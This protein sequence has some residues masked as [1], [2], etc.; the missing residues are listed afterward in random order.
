MNVSTEQLWKINRIR[1]K[2]LP[3]KICI[4]KFYAYDFLKFF[5][6]HKIR[7]FEYDYHSGQPKD[8]DIVF[9]TPGGS[10]YPQHFNNSTQYVFFRR[11]AGFDILRWFGIF[12]DPKLSY[13]V[14]KSS[15]W[16]DND[17]WMRSNVHWVDDSW[18]NQ[19]YQLPDSRLIKSPWAHSLWWHRPFIEKDKYRHVDMANKDGWTWIVIINRPLR[20]KIANW[21]FEN[22]KIFDFRHKFVYDCTPEHTLSAFEPKMFRPIKY[23]IRQGG[24]RSYLYT[25][26]AE[27][28]HRFEDD[29]DSFA[30][31]I[32]TPCGDVDGFGMADHILKPIQRKM[33]FV[34]VG[35]HKY[36]KTLHRMGFRTFH[37]YIDESFD[38]EPDHDKRVTM[39]ME[40]VYHALTNRVVNKNHKA[41]LEICQHNIDHLLD[42]TARHDRDETVIHR[43]IKRLIGY[44]IF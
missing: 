23:D 14:P 21:M 42:I 26:Q 29:Y 13:R 10:E 4:D 22:Q 31:D 39:A 12:D 1:G 16:F 41:I 17:T 44:D 11:I 7:V 8:A 18:L 5:N 15:D 27:L 32:V 34:H 38:N 40:S 19:R 3:I 20:D 25:N 33:P 37:P 28:L 2:Q 35:C 6:R 36:Y 9:L 24:S 43:T 30:I